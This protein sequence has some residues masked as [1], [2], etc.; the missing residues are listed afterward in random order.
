MCCFV[1]SGLLEQRYDNIIRGLA[2]P[3]ISLCPFGTREPNYDQIRGLASPTISLCPFGTREQ[4]TTKSGDSCPR[5]FPCVPSGLW[6]KI[7]TK[8]ADLRPRLFPYVPSGRFLTPHASLRTIPSLHR[9]RSGSLRCGN[10]GLRSLLR[11]RARRCRASSGLR[12]SGSIP[13]CSRVDLSR[14][15]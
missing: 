9:L 4:N 11:D 3:A 12:R 13:R 2:S 14:P 6:N 10:R 8:S 15:E 1:P 5:P 7:T